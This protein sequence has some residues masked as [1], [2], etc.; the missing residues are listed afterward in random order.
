MSVFT[1]IYY[2][3]I[4]CIIHI[5]HSMCECQSV[6]TLV[7]RFRVKNIVNQTVNTRIFIDTRIFLWA[8]LKRVILTSD[9]K[10][11]VSSLITQMKHAIRIIFLA[12]TSY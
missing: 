6:R 10:F 9:F 4:L 8:R 5:I 3:T 12:V 7:C 11:F 1:T 2:S